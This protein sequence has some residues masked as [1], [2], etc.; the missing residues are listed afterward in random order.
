[1]LE[2]P[3]TLAQ[4]L[5]PA[6]LTQALVPVTGGAP[7]SAVEPVEVIRTVATKVRFSAAFP[8]A[9]GGR[10]AFC[11]KGFLDVDSDTARG[12]A[13]TVLESDF[14]AR[15]APKLSVRVP[16]CVATVID[17][18]AQLGIVIMRDL[19]AQGAA[20]APLWKPLAPMRRRRASSSSPGCMPAAYP[21][22]RCP[23]YV[24]GSPSSPEPS[25]YRSRCFRRCSTARGVK[26]CP[27]GRGTQ[28]CSSKPC[29]RSRR[30]TKRVRMC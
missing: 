25:T 13:V 17:R 26:G 16:E 10:E 18:E 21:S 14:Y 9:R 30:A 28:P 22:P 24:G 4:A 19:I 3:R 8:G 29:R 23:G 20:S 15:L 27:H 11:L 12:G 6:W 7:V 2:V 5:D 1:M